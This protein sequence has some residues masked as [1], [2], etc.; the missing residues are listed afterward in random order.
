MTRVFFTLSILL[1]FSM[2]AA[3]QTFYGTTDLS[4]FREGR[5]KEFRD[6]AESPLQDKDFTDFAG[7]NYFPANKKFRVKA[8]FS[9]TRDEK[10]FQ[11]P[12]S[13]GTS[14]K[15]VKYGVLNF[16]IGGR[17]HMLNV[18][19]S[20]P[21]NLAKFPEYAD[22]LFIPFKDQTSGK[23]TYGVGRYIDI[24]MPQDESVVL[25]FNLAYNPNCAYGNEK[26]SCPIPPNLNALSIEIKAGEKKFLNPATSISDSVKK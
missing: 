9:R 8:V 22:L 6:K 11:M 16:D 21:E 24:K 2:F 26:Y 4:E 17:K 15:F 25:D 14:K 10:Y 18:Y 13:S 5:D 20:N 12:T 7:L 19:Q 3:G 1:S 23:E